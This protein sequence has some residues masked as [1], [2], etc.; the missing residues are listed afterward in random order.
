MN[1]IISTKRAIAFLPILLAAVLVAGCGGGG[2]SAK[3]AS[4]DVAVV[5]SD[6]ISKADF[7]TLMKQAKASFAKQTPPRPFPKQ[8]TAEYETVKS[9]AVTLLVQQA[10]RQEK[11]SSEGINISDKQIE[12]RL[13]QIKK[14]YFQG[15]QKKYLAQLKKQGVSDAQVHQDIRSQL[16]SEA[17]FN[18]VSKNVK[19]SDKDV[20][21]YYSAH[22]QL[23][24]RAQTRDVRH[25]L[26]K[27]KPSADSLYAQ[28]KAGNTQTWCK[29][30]KK[31]SQDPSS[32]D[33]C[34]KLTVSKGQTVAEFDKV[35]FTEKTKVVHAPVHNAQYGWFVI[36]PLSEVHP[37][38]T[39]PEKQVAST[40]RQQLLQQKKNQ[41]MTDWVSNLS[42]TF[43][44]GSKIKFQ[45]GFAPSPD[46]CASTTTNATTT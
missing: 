30:A 33:A 6:H 3:L 26:V 29:L 41:A 11:A 27:S 39:T 13:T 12:A 34:G 16:I 45:V 20:H 8:G 32:K 44:G 18:K 38:S 5:G 31:F 4:D 43:C 25:I 40:I 21:D 42:K 17:V 35:A 24:S 23:Y 36:E 10:E 14:Q 2:G 37:K 19:V 15:S 46:P 1:G 22:P 28:L 9:Q 7:D